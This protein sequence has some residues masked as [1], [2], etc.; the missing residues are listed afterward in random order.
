MDS[1]QR[2]VFYGLGRSV[3]HSQRMY[4]WK[5]ASSDHSDQPVRPR[6]LQSPALIKLCG[7]ASWSKS[8]QGTYVLMYIISQ[9]AH[10]VKMTSYQRRCDVMTSHRRWYDVIL[11][12]CACWAPVGAHFLV[13]R[14]LLIWDEMGCAMRK[15]VSSGICG[16]RR[17]RSAYAS[18]QSDQGLCCP[19]TKSFDTKEQ[20]PGW[21]LAH[22]Q[23]DVNQAHFA[24][25]RR[26]IL[27]DT[28]QIKCALQQT[29]WDKF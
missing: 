23:D 5:Y 22:V 4:L 1:N 26:H 3:F 16:Q 20:M 2:K 14:F 24:H 29:I 7:W 9:W 10:N 11:M 19:L 13:I 27:M 25:A 15:K 21:D 12:L 18:A 28:A 17:P 6:F 8:S